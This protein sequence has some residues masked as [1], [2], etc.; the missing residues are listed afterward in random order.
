MQPHGLVPLHDELAPF[1]EEVPAHVV[2]L[3]DEAYVEYAE[4]ERRLDVPAVLAR[5]RCRL[6]VLRTFSKF[7]ALSGFRVGYA[8]G[9]PEVVSYLDR[10]EVSFGIA[11]VSQFVACRGLA[12]T[13]ARQRTYDEN[14][15]QRDRIGRGLAALGIPY[16][17]SQTSF[18]LFDTPVDPARMRE[19]LRAQGLVLPNVNVFLQNYSVFPVGRP[20]HNQAL[21]DYLARH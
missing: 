8:L 19:E 7:F 4:P 2:L 18:V 12:D 17:P 1:L 9:R 15:A 3:L 14:V 21:L 10:S 13:E 11:N 16:M 5:A 20:E 6:V